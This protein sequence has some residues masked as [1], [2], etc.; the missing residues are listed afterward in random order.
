MNSIKIYK[1]MQQTMGGNLF[2]PLFENSDE[3]CQKNILNNFPLI[4]NQRI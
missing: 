1:Y 4:F 2:L 3:K